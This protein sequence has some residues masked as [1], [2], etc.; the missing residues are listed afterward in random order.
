MKI[1]SFVTNGN[2]SNTPR[3]TTP[4]PTT[5]RPTPIAGS[6]LSYCYNYCNLKSK[7]GSKNNNDCKKKC[8]TDVICY[9]NLVDCKNKQSNEI[10][11]CINSKKNF[12]KSIPDN[13]SIGASDVRKWSP[14]WYPLLYAPC[15][16][17]CSWYKTYYC[18]GNGVDRN[19]IKACAE[20]NQICVAACK[21]YGMS[22]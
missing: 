18:S 12:C 19:K 6:P 20:L 15:D 16:E 11:G 2:Q 17:A 9:N 1:E 4:S 5:P 22:K 3:P 10:E 8:N 13:R 14:S 21:K 7:D